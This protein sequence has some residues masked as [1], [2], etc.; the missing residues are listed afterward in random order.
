MFHIKREKQTEGPVLKQNCI[1]IGN[2][3]E[4]MEYLTFPSLE[5]T[6]LIRHLF[7]TR[8]GGIS[9]GDFSSMNLS[10]SRGDNP[11]S[12]MENYG[13]IAKVL[14]CGPE[15]M[16]A[17]H[18]THTTNIRKVTEADKGKGITVERDY[19]NVDGLI[20]NEPGI[21]LVT[22]FADCVPLFFVD[23]VHR[24]VGLAHSGWRGTESEMGAC[25]VKAM[26]AAYGTK[27]EDLYTAIGPSICVNCYEVSEDVA[28]R[29]ERF[30]GV[31]QKG[32]K[33]D[34]YQLNLW[35]ANRQILR[36]AGVREERIAVTDICT[37]CNSEYLFSHRASMGRRG[38]LAAFLEL[39]YI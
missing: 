39:V 35:E 13:R 29:F 38:N 9:K 22:Y 25:M 12:V 19:E 17:S 2:S 20:C 10:F 23:P 37:C 34:K 26:R 6:G 31:V 33:P 14:E 21:V 4:E 8:T 7:T 1:K 28:E 24:A 11:E 15:D 3:G 5:K 30:P 32:R 36:Q 27:P 18:Q 16:V